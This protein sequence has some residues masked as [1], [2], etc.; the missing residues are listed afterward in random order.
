M[1]QPA[2]AEPAGPK[3]S[4]PTKELEQ[5]AA[6]LS[7]LASAGEPLGATALA[8]RFKQGRRVL[9]QIEAVLAALVRVGGLA[10][11]PDGGRGFMIRRAA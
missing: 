7:M 11:S 2:A 4:F 1:N 9:P 10:H 3:P 5:T 6:V 8:V